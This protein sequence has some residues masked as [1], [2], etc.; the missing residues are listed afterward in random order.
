MKRIGNKNSIIKKGSKRMAV[1]AVA[2][3][4]TVM[5][6]VPA[7]AAQAAGSPVIEGAPA[8]PGGMQATQ[9]NHEGT[10]I[11]EAYWALLG[12]NVLE[13]NEINDRIR[14]F[15]PTITNNTGKINDAV[16]EIKDQK[17]D[18]LDT[19]ADLK[20]SLE[21]AKQMEP[22]PE[23]DETILRLQFG[24]A[25]AER[26]RK[27]INNAI[28]SL[29]SEKSATQTAITRGIN[30][31]ARGVQS[32]IIGYKTLLT[33]KELLKK[34][35]ELN[36]E[37][38]NTQ[39]ALASVGMAT[40]IDVNK[41]QADMLSAQTNISSL[42]GTET[43]LYNQIKVLC[44][45]RITDMP[46]LGEVPAADVNRMAAYNPEVDYIYAAGNNSSV[47]ASRSKAGSGVASSELRNQSVAQNTDL[48][49]AKLQTAYANVLA[50]KQDYDAAAA[51][52]QAAQINKNSA[53]VSYKLGMMSKAQYLGAL[54]AATQKEAQFKSTDLALTQAMN[55][56]EGAVDGSIVLD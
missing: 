45:W 47:N 15:N 19:I 20:E 32:L 42:E 30:Q 2:A 46:I 26:G 21:L 11:T 52:Y 39:V 10:N 14:Y 31:M 37:I 50:A 48:V 5:S 34:L 55:N 16:E 18:I 27:Q 25:Q 17:D 12:D 53:E 24:I 1:A 41:A 51:G 28:Q 9:P 6:V 49:R 13:Y 8:G 29:T 35:S 4:F 22:G 23:R 3:L 56:Y 7:F 33:Q 40:Q 43:Q 54:V 44:G 36:Q 38:Y